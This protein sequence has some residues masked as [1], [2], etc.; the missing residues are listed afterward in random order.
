MAKTYR[1]VETV[2]PDEGDKLKAN[3]C[4]TMNFRRIWNSNQRDFYGLYFNLFGNYNGAIKGT[5]GP[6]VIQN[7]DLTSNCGTCTVYGYNH[8][9]LRVNF[10][11]LQ[12]IFHNAFKI[13]IGYRIKLINLGTRRSSLGMCS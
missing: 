1:P 3:S 12:K 13:L 6:L 10:Y 7:Q 9:G 8:L 11:F 2:S 4:S 5:Q